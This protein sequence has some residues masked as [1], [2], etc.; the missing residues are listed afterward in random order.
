LI[1]IFQ[2]T[3]IE[4][5]L[6]KQSSHAKLLPT[7]ERKE[8]DASMIEKT[9]NKIVPTTSS[10]ALEITPKKLVETPNES[11]SLLLHQEDQ[12]V[13]DLASISIHDKMNDPSDGVSE[14]ESSS[15]NMAHMLQQIISKVSKAEKMNPEI[16]RFLDLSKKNEINVSFLFDK[17]SESFVVDRNALK[18]TN[19]ESLSTMGSQEI[20]G[21]KLLL[22]PFVK[23]KPLMKE[24][25]IQKVECQDA[26]VQTDDHVKEAKNDRVKNDEGTASQTSFSIDNRKKT[27]PSFRNSKVYKSMEQSRTE[28]FVDEKS[29]ACHCTNPLHICPLCAGMNN[30]S[31]QKNTV[32]EQLVAEAQKSNLSLIDSESVILSDESCLLNHETSMIKSLAEIVLEMESDDEIPLKSVKSDNLRTAGI[33]DVLTLILQLNPL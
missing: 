18:A 30:A 10:N 32:A 29:K 2:N 7:Q 14:E 23:E 16:A 6:Q 21:S 17:D 3:S 27:R 26:F 33:D 13:V 19:S 4:N 15:V 9:Q 11:K 31:Q 28:A 25:A 22:N 1:L 20:F 12:A 8:R 24:V 5:D